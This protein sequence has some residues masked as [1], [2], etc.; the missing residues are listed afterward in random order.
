MAQDTKAFLRATLV[1]Q[2]T[3]Q[4]DAYILEN[5]EGAPQEA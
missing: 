2:L 4:I 3:I 1:G 5:E